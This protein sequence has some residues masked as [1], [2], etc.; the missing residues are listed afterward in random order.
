MGGQKKIVFTREEIVEG[1]ADS[2]SYYEVIT[3]KVSHAYERLP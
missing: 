3:A 2:V 1:S